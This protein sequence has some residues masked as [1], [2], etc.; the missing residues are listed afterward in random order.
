MN[1]LTDDQ[2][3]EW[4]SG[5]GTRETL[6]HIESCPLCHSETLALRDDISR[7]VVTRRKQARQARV[8][9]QAKTISPKQAFATH[10]LHWAGA[11][12]LALLLATPTAWML[13]PHTTTTPP[14]PVAA[15]PG[16]V[17]PTT[18]M[19]DD[20]LLEA[21]NNDLNRD[22]PQALAPI[23]AITVARNKIAAASTG[24]AID[25]NDTVK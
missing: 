3:A 2:L 19:S 5:V 11:A 23:S 24:A 4:L 16:I 12:A 17:Q 22:V 21:V 7:Y 6:A 10:R 14:H 18:A 25:T 15:T 13:K 8:T 9:H 1:H 20:E